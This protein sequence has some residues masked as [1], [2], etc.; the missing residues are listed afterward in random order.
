MSPPPTRTH[1][2]LSPQTSQTV[3]KVG[4]TP[5]SKHCEGPSSSSS[6][7]RQR[8]RTLVPSPSPA[9]LLRREVQEA[10]VTFNEALASMR[11]RERAFRAKGDYEVRRKWR[12]GWAEGWRAL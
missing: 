10:D 2:M 6:A 5:S 7:H 1:E 9:L 11:N 4:P 12:G 8:S 3:F